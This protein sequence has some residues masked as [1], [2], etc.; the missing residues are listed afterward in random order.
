MTI[1]LVILKKLFS[2]TLTCTDMNLKTITHNH[3]VISKNNI[4]YHIPYFTYSDTNL[5]TNGHTRDIR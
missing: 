4:N 2:N 5:K 3:D 1:M